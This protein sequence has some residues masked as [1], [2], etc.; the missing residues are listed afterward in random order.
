M[1][2][3]AAGNGCGENGVR[4]RR[5]SRPAQP[6]AMDLTGKV[7]EV[8]DDR[9]P[10]KCHLRLRQGYGGRSGAGG[11]HVHADGPC[12]VAAPAPRAR[13]AD[14]DRARRLGSLDGGCTMSLRAELIQ[15]QGSH[16]R[17]SLSHRRSRP[18]TPS[19]H[20][21]GPP[22]LRDCHYWKR[23]QCNW[24]ADYKINRSRLWSEPRRDSAEAGVVQVA[25]LG[26][27]V[28]W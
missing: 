1:N 2:C 11:S 20:E 19:A 7:V 26:M 14:P 10:G 8:L 22:H 17:L 16:E 9:K 21:A 13:S 12:D 24:K 15:M 25:V 27:R 23:S 18:G 3:S 4:L 28:H 6:L 5:P